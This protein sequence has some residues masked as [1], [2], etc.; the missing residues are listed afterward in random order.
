MS[1]LSPTFRSYHQKYLLQRHPWLLTALDIEPGEDLLNSHVACRLN[2][3]VGGYGKPSD[4]DQE[5]EKLGLNEKMADYVR[6]QMKRG[7]YQ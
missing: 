2:G 4:F 5:W 7:R 1:I 6:N 3:Y